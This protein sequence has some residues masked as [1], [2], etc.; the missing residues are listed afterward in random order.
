MAE[1]TEVRAITDELRD[2]DAERP[3]EDRELPPGVEVFAIRGSFFFGSAQKFSEVIGTVERAP[4]V[5]ILQMRDVIS[6]DATGLRALEEVWGRFRGRGATL[7]IAGIH[8]QPMFA[9]RNAGL[10]ERI[11]EENVL[12]NLPD[13]L[14]R[15]Q[16]ILDGQP[17]APVVSPSA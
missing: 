13:A 6:I 7:L 8:A 5:V 4:R 17:E 12:G 15:A 3:L 9:L 1:V 11:G 16:R 10:L 2:E 14:A